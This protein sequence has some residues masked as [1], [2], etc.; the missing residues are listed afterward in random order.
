[1]VG[2]RAYTSDMNYVPTSLHKHYKRAV[3]LAYSRRN[4][5]SQ[6]YTLNWDINVVFTHVRV[7]PSLPATLTCLMEIRRRA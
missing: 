3:A 6:Y 4:R 5:E 1:M 2:Y 7:T